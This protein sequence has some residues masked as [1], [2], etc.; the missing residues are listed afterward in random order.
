MKDKSKQVWN[1]YRDNPKKFTIE[2]YNIL[3]EFY[4]HIGHKPEA[5]MLS[6]LNKVFVEDLINRYSSLELEEIRFAINK[7]I[8]DSDPP[9]FVNVPTWNKF[10]REYKESERKRR[11]SNQVEEY[12]LYKKRI[13][14]V[15]KLIDKREVKKIGRNK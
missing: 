7:G 1:L 9:I 14:S 5:E 11:Q 6:I 4:I 15:S 13:E 8:K 2:C 12:S 3:T 10:I